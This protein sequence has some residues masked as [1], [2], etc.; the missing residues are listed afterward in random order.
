[1]KAVNNYIIITPIKEE[2]KTESGFIMQDDKAEFR[3]LKVLMWLF[4][5]LFMTI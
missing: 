5:V 1:M 3:Y 4:I 2:K